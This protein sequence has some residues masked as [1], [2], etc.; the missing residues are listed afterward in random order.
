MKITF[1][2]NIIVLLLTCVAAVP[3][4]AK[5]HLEVLNSTQTAVT[6]EW[7][8]ASQQRWKRR[9]L[10]SG[11]DFF[12]AREM[13]DR[14]VVFRVR[15]AGSS[16]YLEWEGDQVERVKQ[17]QGIFRYK[18]TPSIRFFGG[19]VDLILTSEGGPVDGDYVR[20]D[21][22][23]PPG[24][25]KPRRSQATPPGTCGVDMACPGIPWL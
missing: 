18:D 13:A 23:K 12:L 8:M 9:D 14:T 10:A 22:P 17:G 1:T 3:A 15:A 19:H 21:P 5:L 20:I 7:W 24:S 11:E 25:Q 4:A 2:A 16:D 6:F